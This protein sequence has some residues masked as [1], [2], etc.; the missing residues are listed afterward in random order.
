MS[1]QRCNCNKAPSVVYF[2]MTEDVLQKG[3]TPTPTTIMAIYDYL[4]ATPSH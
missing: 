3:G 4:G 2:V 1:P